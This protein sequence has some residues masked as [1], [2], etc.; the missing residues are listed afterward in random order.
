MES[1]F[2]SSA[3]TWPRIELSVWPS[4][5]TRAAPN[6]PTSFPHAFQ[7]VVD[8]GVVERAVVASSCAGPSRW[9]RSG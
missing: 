9:E 3:G 2:T 8:V 6:V 4:M 1:V 5:I 7:H